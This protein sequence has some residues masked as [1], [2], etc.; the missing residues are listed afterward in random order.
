MSKRLT[1]LQ[2][3]RASVYTNIENMQKQYDGKEMDSEARAKFTALVDECS[4]LDKQIKTE[5]RFLEVQKASAQRNLERNTQERN[6]DDSKLETRAFVKYLLGEELTAEEKAV[7]KRA[8][9][10][11]AG[12]VLIPS[13]I[14]PYI[15]KAIAGATGM[16]QAA[17]II[18]TTTGGD[19]VWPTANN[20]GV[21]AKIVAEYG[22]SQ[23][24]GKTFGSKTLKAYTYRTDIIPV[25]YELL[26]DSAF[27]VEQYIGELLAQEFIAGLNADFTNGTG[28][29]APRGI[30]K[31]AK[32][33]SLAGEGVT[34]DDIIEVMKAVP[35]GYH[36]A[37]KF[38][39]NAKTMLNLALVKDGNERPIWTP[40]MSAAM[41][42]TVFGKEI[43]LNDD[44]EDNN[45][46][47][48]DF[49]KYKVRMVK[50]F[51]AAV[52]KEA[53]MEYLSI[54]IIGYGRADGALL[55]AGTTPVAILK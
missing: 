18:R 47:F 15:E 14:A 52:M 51:S 44:L 8:I 6:A 11:T 32:A 30:T 1:E 38:M 22:Q 35:S 37:A 41:P 9:N 29:G 49:K 19:L 17:D 23:K 21:K 36:A 53:L 10:G 48:G 40:S 28:E 24:A 27:N 45:I 26:Q 54:G 7:Q 5:E 3:K 55:D 33:V 34:Y 50:D 13:S 25:S 20:A 42:A 12:S 39:M 43:I 4:D 16:L 46:L 2:E 31:D